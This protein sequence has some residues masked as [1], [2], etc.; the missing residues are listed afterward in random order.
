MSLETL[1]LINRLRASAGSA[2]VRRWVAMCREDRRKMRN[3][4]YHC[5]V[6]DY[7]TNSQTV[8]STEK[9]IIL[10]IPGL[11]SLHRNSSYTLLAEL[12]ANERYIAVISAYLLECEP[13]FLRLVPRHSLPQR[14]P[15]RACHQILWLSVKPWTHPFPTRDC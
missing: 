4:G 8:E 6:C 14:L 7:L 15:Q 9:L 5:P 10:Q 12:K 1:L 3:A 11:S 13:E 2:I